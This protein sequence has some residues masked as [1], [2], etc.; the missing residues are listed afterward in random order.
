ME[1]FA[2]LVRRFNGADDGTVDIG[3][4]YLVITVPG[5]Q[6]DPAATA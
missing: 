2:D 4:D 1:G 5:A 3:S 6:A